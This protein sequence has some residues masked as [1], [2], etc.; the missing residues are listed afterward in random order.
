[1]IVCSNDKSVDIKEEVSKEILN[2]VKGKEKILNIC[3]LPYNSVDIFLNVIF[4]YVDKRK[5]I[6][7]ITGEN[8]NNI[9]IINSLKKNSNFRKYSYVR[10]ENT[11]FENSLVICNHEIAM[12]LEDVFDLVI[13]DDI[14][15]F[16]QYNNYEIMENIIKNSTENNKC[17]CYSL[18][19]IFVNAR[20]IVIPVRS[21]SMPL[22]EPRFI[23]TRINLNEEI[24]FVMYDYLNFSMECNRKVIIYV[25]DNEIVVS[26]YKYLDNFKQDL[27][28]NIFYFIKGETDIKVYDNFLKIKKSIIITNE[29]SDFGYKLKDIDVIVYLAENKIFDCKKLMYICGKVGVSENTSKGEVIFLSG[30]VTIEMEKAKNIARGYNKEAW[31]RNLLNL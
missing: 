18:Q 6:L 4:Y 19:S 24:P 28:K 15:C 22:P 7:Y 16:S 5:K 27:T 11:Y 1:M 26:L 3:T 30:E 25:P 14:S 10:K 31:E 20:E 2:W 23:T 29:F 17:I 13:Y 12:K 9:A 21:N 8:E